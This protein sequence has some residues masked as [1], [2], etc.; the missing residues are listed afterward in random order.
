MNDEPQ[1]IDPEFVNAESPPKI[2]YPEIRLSLIDHEGSG[3]SLISRGRRAL[4]SA[5][6]PLDVMRE[7]TAESTSRSSYDALASLMREWFTIE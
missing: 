3:F 4:Q 1:Y 6:V 7:F 2:R 5:G